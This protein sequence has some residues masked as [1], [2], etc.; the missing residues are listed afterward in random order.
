MIESKTQQR[1]CKIHNARFYHLTPRAINYSAYNSELNLLALTRLVAAC[2]LQKQSKQSFSKNFGLNC[3]EDASIE[4]WNIQH[5]PYLQQTIVGSPDASVEAIAWAGT[6]LFSTGL[7]GEL[8]EWDLQLLEAKRKL[9]LT[10]NA[11]WCLDVSKQNTNIVIGTDSGYINVFDVSNADEVNYVKVFDRQEG[12]ILCCKFDYSGEFVVTGSADT[13]RVWELKSGHAIYKMST[14]R[15]EALKETVIWSLAVLSDFTIIAGDSRGYVT[16]WDGKLGAQVDSFA[17]MKFGDVLSVAV[18]EDEK[19]FACAGIDPKIKLYALTDIKTAGDKVVAK[20]VKFFQRSVH[21]H[22]VKTLQFIN[23]RV[24]SGGIDGYLGQ[25]NSS[26]YKACQFISKYGP[27]LEQPCS[28]VA[29]EKRILLL[30]YLNYIELWKLG[31]PTEKVHL[32]E[33]EEEKRTFFAL[34][35]GLQKLLELR[36]KDDATIVCT[37]ISPNGNI[38]IYS[39]N[40]GIRI[41][42]LKYEV[43]APLS[44]DE[45]VLPEIYHFRFAFFQDDKIIGLNKLRDL[46]EQFTTAAKIEFSSDSKTVYLVKRNRT[47]DVF[48]VLVSDENDEEVHYR[49]T[50]DA[51]KYLKAPISHIVVSNCGEFLVCAGLCCNI[52]VWKRTKK[53]GWAHHINLPKYPLAPVA[54]AIHKNSP[55]LVVAFSDAKIFEY[56]LEEWRFLCSSSRQFVKNQDTHV[57]RNIVLD[58]RD[59]DVFILHNE[60]FLFVVKKTKVCDRHSIRLEITPKLIIINYFPLFVSQGGE[61]CIACRKKGERTAIKV[62]R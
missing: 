21:E 48:Q 32:V 35:D 43:S 22:D 56:H 29:S 61:R 46:P 11:A 36:A 13:I 16:I 54:M 57:I 18:S 27:F 1:M 44:H 7:T 53:D 14:G 49:E 26:K 34:E 47:I 39:T 8:I 40:A 30:K 20:W 3:R 38:L 31:T 5:A 15:L 9:L 10:G 2:R 62:D 17:V 55:K 12:K 50:I 45:S 52:S 28:I 42:R 58:P 60:T 24:F 4:I 59:E 41:F 37:S 6:R 33:D 19:M 23:G 51:Q 25:S